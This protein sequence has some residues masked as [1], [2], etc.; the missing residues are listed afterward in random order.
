MSLAPHGGVL[1]IRVNEAYDV[2]HIALEIELDLIAFADLELVGIGAYSPIQGFL[3]EKDYLSVVENMRL[4]GG[5][6]WTL[7]IS[8]PVNE[9]KA[10]ELKIGDTVRLTYQGET[11]GVIDIEDIYTPDKKKK[12]STSIKPMIS[13]IRA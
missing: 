12:R 11:Y 1:V 4:A 3:T 10:A 9:R 6:V 8:L 13:T 2:Q 7:P 5:Q